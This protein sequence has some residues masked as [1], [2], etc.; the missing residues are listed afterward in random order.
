MKNLLFTILLLINVTLLAQT[1]TTLGDALTT[2]NF[3][4]VP[5]LV[6]SISNV[7]ALSMAIEYDSSMVSFEGYQFPVSPLDE[8]FFALDLGNEIRIT[9]L[10]DTAGVNSLS[11][12]GGGILFHLVFNL[13]TYG[14][15]QLLWSTNQ[16]D[17]E[18]ADENANVIN[19]LWIDGEI[20][21]DI[22][23]STLPSS[24]G[25][26][27]N[28][29]SGTMLGVA[30]I[31]SIAASGND[32]IAAFDPNGNCAGFN[33][34]VD[35]GDGNTYINLVIYGD[36]P[37]TSGIDEGLNVGEEFYLKIWD[38]SDNLIIDYMDNYGVSIPLIG[39]SN[40]NG[41]PMP[42]F[43]NYM[44][45]YNFLTTI[46]IGPAPNA[47]FAADV[48]VVNVGD[49]V[50]FID[51]S[52]DN[53]TSWAW[54]IPGANPDGSTDQNPV[55]VYST[56]G[57]FNVTL[58]TFNPAGSDTEIKYNYILVNDTSTTI[59]PES[60]FIASNTIIEV[61]ETINFFDLT[62]NNPNSWTWL[63]PGGSPNASSL[64]NPIVTYNSSGI[65]DV[66]LVS[67]NSAGSDTEVK[68]AYITVVDTSININ[69]QSSNEILFYNNYNKGEVFVSS[70][71]KGFYSCELYSLDGKLVYKS[72]FIDE[73]TLLTNQLEEG[74]Y[75][76][77]IRR[78][79]E[80]LKRE[81][82]IVFD[83]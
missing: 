69:E 27:P 20:T 16:G 26:T 82:I 52:T 73:L 7:D 60:D 58:V 77:A 42:N 37:T 78:N 6:N 18:Y 45:E 71:I 39:W 9:W 25:F 21:Y 2:N 41:A 62:N 65:Y 22:L 28:P 51:L 81:K 30:L 46:V 8:D 5:V 75:I 15:S 19:S 10:N 74:I 31:D 17:C 43:S 1:T 40:N 67:F 47:S 23:P 56:P 3:A 57:L 53:P 48:T 66:T 63:F 11:L 13:H 14:T 12:T 50:Q 55:V 76:V 80:I 38:V 68:T 29:Y 35:V 70:S 54:L 59:I 36:D 79:T 32:Y 44:D 49:T 64:S 34:L 24:F 83:L 72:Q 33:Q 61:G 4:V